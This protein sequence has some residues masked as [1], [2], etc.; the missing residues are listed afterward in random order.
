M[1]KIYR[2]FL[3]FALMAVAIGIATTAAYE[4]IFKINLDNSTTTTMDLT[5]SQWDDDSSSWVVPGD[6]IY[7]VDDPVK[8]NV[9]ASGGGAGIEGA[10]VTIK[11][12]STDFE[13]IT[14]VTGDL[15][16]TFSGSEITEGGQIIRVKAYNEGYQVAQDDIYVGYRGILSISQT[17][18]YTRTIIDGSAVD[19]LEMYITPTITDSK[20]GDVPVEGANIT[21]FVYDV[22]PASTDATWLSSGDGGATTGQSALNPQWRF[23]DA[24]GKVTF[25]IEVDR[26]GKSDVAN[27]TTNTSVEKPGYAQIYA[28]TQNDVWSNEACFIA[29]ATYGSPENKNLDTLRLFRDTILESNPVSTA[30][31]NAYYATS[32]PVAYV[33]SENDGL[34]TATRVLLISPSVLFAKFWLN[35]VTS[36]GFILSVSLALLFFEDH[37][38]SILKGIGYGALTLLTF[39]GVV[40]TLGYLGYTTL[41]CAVLGACLLPFM[42]PSALI[43]SFFGGFKGIL[44]ARRTTTD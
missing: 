6:S 41:F 22:L 39:S 14:N 43:I 12:H 34:R 15:M 3:V 19:Y 40:F 35:P 24:S 37:R 26:N 31:V 16:Y 28:E 4:P 25:E 23:T 30:L 9:R 36:I 17:D 44:D 21:V 7:F 5:I 29:T 8:I 18:T 33:L 2:L 27:M 10:N 20:N 38:R 1:K 32:P 13:G 42:V 11:G